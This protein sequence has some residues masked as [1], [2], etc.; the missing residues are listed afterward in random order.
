LV[1]GVL[2]EVQLR[3]RTQEPEVVSLRFATRGTA[4]VP[5][6]KG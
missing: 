2:C 5:D 4:V 1:A 6:A 3:G